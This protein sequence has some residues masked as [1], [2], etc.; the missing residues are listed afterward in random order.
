MQRLI[1]LAPVVALFIVFAVNTVRAANNEAVASAIE[2]FITSGQINLGS[3]R[4]DERMFQIFTYYQDRNFKPI[5]TR[6]SGVKTKGR[7]LLEALQAAGEH[8]LDPD[9][10]SVADIAERI[11][12]KNPEVLAELDL[13]LS[14]VFADF[15]QHLSKGRINP[16]KINRDLAIQSRGPGPLFL[17]DG[18]EQAGRSTALSRDRAAANPALH[19]PERCTCKLSPH[20]SGWAAGPRSRPARC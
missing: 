15:A 4:T 12:A 19:S 2:A 9:R 5:W 1:K 18:A 7:K 14:D 13:L 20:R 6:D 17:I 16:S 11:D 8:G 10:Y 3:E